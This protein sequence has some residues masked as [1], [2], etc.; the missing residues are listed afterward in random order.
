MK[1]RRTNA[2]LVDVIYVEKKD[3]KQAKT[4]LER[5]GSLQ[6]DFRLT[7][8]ATSPHLIALPIRD[9][10][11]V[12]STVTIHGRGRQECLYST[13]TAALGNGGRLV[14][15]MNYQDG[16]DPTSWSA[17]QTA[18]FQVLPCDDDKQQLLRER[19]QQLSND[20]CPK[21]L[22]L[23]GDDRTIVIPR[24]AMQRTIDP[25]LG[26]LL[27]DYEADGSIIGPRLWQNLATIL[28]SQRVVR[29]GEIDPESGARQSQFSILW[30]SEQDSSGWITVTENGIRQSFDLT[31]VMFSRGNVTEKRR[32][33]STLV[34][35][36]E[37]VLDLYAGIGY[38]TL[39]ALI[40]GKA[41]HVTCC[42]WNP[43]AGMCLIGRGLLDDLTLSA[44]PRFP[45]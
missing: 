34:Q 35:P 26:Q 38:F 42:E 4:E 43:D 6:S 14:R 24:K 21:K 9:S 30:Q 45:L 11:A 36:N 3:A 37:S 15:A 1:E 8:S 32:F 7:Q 16:S 40:H 39:P 12:L 2:G 17:L 23:F 22:E 41:Q 20:T 25:M 5:A 13:R 18:L 31:R 44:C 33:G 10:A 27:D 19:I 29:R 28:Q